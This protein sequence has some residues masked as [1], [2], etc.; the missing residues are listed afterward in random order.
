M[1]SLNELNL[2][3]SRCI[4]DKW[5]G[6]IDNENETGGSID[7]LITDGNT[8]FLIENKIWAEDQDKQLVRYGN[9]YSKAP[10]FYLTLFDSNE[11]SDA[12]KRYLNK[13]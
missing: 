1:N 10:I 9:A 2:N 5:L 7:L 12:S 11:V 4:K 13:K 3:S 8:S 6:K